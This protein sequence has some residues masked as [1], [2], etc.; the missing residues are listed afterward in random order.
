MT[1]KLNYL[2]SYLEKMEVT[3]ASPDYKQQ[4]HFL[5]SNLQYILGSRPE[6]VH[7][8]ENVLHSANYYL[9]NISLPLNEG[10]EASLMVRHLRNYCERFFSKPHSEPRFEPVMNIQS[11]FLH[12][13]AR[14][15]FDE[16]KA[17]QLSS[18][19]VFDS[20]FFAKI[21]GIDVFQILVDEEGLIKP[22]VDNG[23]IILPLDE[24]SPTEE[25]QVK[26][27]PAGVQ[28]Q[29][30]SAS[31]KRRMRRNVKCVQ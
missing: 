14:E 25:V 12:I 28:V 13:K 11:P 22:A 1:E 6:D 24:P 21:R 20:L 7:L 9:G 29:V 16:V 2:E 19:Q 23:W 15:F 5:L 3:L 30:L 8:S 17:Q 31:K 4:L 10:D 26:P 18:K 27:A